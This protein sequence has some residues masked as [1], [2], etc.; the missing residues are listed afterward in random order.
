MQKEKNKKGFT[1]IEILVTIAIAGILAG[2]IMT[3][4]GRNPDQDVRLER[5]RLVT[6]LR[7]V[8]NKALS[9]EQPSQAGASG[10]YTGSTYTCNIC[11]YGVK[12]DA[13]GNIQAYY[14]TRANQDATCDPSSSGTKYENE[15]F[16]PRNG[17]TLGGIVSGE[18]V[19]FLAP[20]GKIYHYN[21]S[22]VLVTSD[23][24][25]N[26]SKTGGPTIP[27]TIKSGGIIE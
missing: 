15:I 1:L 17:V 20:Q 18:K 11:G 26:L 7:N 21:N 8:Q 23:A 9:A 3:N 4:F 25:I 2:T 13:S 27:V 6:F 12:L 14:A 16:Y 24:Q 5:D 10:C 19:F 22:G